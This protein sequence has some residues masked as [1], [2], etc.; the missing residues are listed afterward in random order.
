MQT[1]HAN[2]IDIRY[3]IDGR[4]G[5]W[6]VMIHS[7]ATD[8]SLWDEQIPALAGFRVLRYDVR[9]HGASTATEPP[10]DFDLFTAD[11]LALMDG[12]AIDR[13]H[14][15]GI[16]MGGMIAQH[17]AL[18]AP[19]RVDRLVLVSTTS[20]YPAQARALWD[21]RIASV[22]AGGM[23]PLVAPTLE[24]WFTA[25]YRDEHPE[26]MARI[27]ALIAATPPSGY[28]G[29]GRAIATLDTTERLAQLRCPTLVMVGAGDAGTPPGMG[30]KI[31]EQ[32]PGARFE[33][34]AEASHLCNVEQAATFNRLLT[35]FLR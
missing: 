32:I 21:E 8:L 7:L 17:V 5:P 10:Y 4:D 16:S 14:L 29:A 31:A 13:A 30:R 6:L 28:I 25:P 15:C 27:G 1:L 19:Q 20:G 33:S 3:R 18:A 24:R 12:L 26:V 9:G 35:E 11:L 34:I 2:G 23:A 22:V